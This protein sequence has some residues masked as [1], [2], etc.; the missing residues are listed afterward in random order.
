MARKNVCTSQYGCKI[1]FSNI[2][3]LGL[4]E[5]MDAEPMDMDVAHAAV[6]HGISHDKEGSSS[7]GRKTWTLG[8]PAMGLMHMNPTSNGQK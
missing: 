6:C 7:G 3:R 1:F 8:N 2:F 5:S 4:V